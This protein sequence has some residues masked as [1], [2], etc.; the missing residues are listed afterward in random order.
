MAA[1][2]SGRQAQKINK[3]RDKIR[4]EVFVK[5]QLSHQIS[6]FAKSRASFWCQRMRTQGDSHFP[7]LRL[8]IDPGLCEN[9]VI[10]GIKT[11]LWI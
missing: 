3:I 10:R 9:M 2:I 1:M 6:L 11:T 5:L 8:E 7:K 4:A